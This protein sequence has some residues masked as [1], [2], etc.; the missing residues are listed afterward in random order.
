MG[1]M[2]KFNVIK[3]NDPFLDAHMA[4]GGAGHASLKFPGFMTSIN[5]GQ[6]L[7]RLIV[8]RIK[9]LNGIFNIVNPLA[10][11]DKTVVVASLIQ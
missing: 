8:G 11:K 7:L 2:G 10:K 3:R 6:G 4:E 1:L 9:K 5:D